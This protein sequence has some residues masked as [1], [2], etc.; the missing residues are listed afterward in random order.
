MKATS[1]KGAIV[2][3]SYAGVVKPNIHWFPEFQMW[4]CYEHGYL[5][6]GLGATPEE[7]Y[8]AFVFLNS[9]RRT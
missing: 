8:E 6:G 7:A 5:H 4:R 3:W 2:R 1:A 9:E